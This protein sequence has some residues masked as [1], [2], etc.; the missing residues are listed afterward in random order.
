MVD[1]LG[2]TSLDPLLFIQKLITNV[3]SIQATLMRR[4]SVLTTLPVHLVFPVQTISF[5]LFVLCIDTKTEPINVK[6][7]GWYSP[8]YLQTSL[9]HY[10]NGLPYFERDQGPM[11]LKIL[12]P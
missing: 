11:L 2:L 12:R 8:N 7:L 9:D 5:A 1:L 3:L 6:R 10:L 4:S